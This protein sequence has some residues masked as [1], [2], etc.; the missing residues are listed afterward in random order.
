MMESRKQHGTD[1]HLQLALQRTRA[2]KCKNHAVSYSGQINSRQLVFINLDSD[3]IYTKQNTTAAPTVPVL[4]AQASTTLLTA[5]KTTLPTGGFVDVVN[6]ANSPY[7]AGWALDNVEQLVSV[8]GGMMLVNSD[9][10]SL[11]FASNGSGGFTTPAGD[12]STL[13]QNGNG[14][15][16]RTLADGT[17]IE[18]N[19]SGQETST[20]DTNGNTT[21]FNY[22]GNLLTSITDMNDQTTTLAY[23]NGQLTSIADPANRTATLAYSGSQLT[24]ITDVGGNLWQYGYDASNDLTTLTD[25]NT[26]TTTF[27]YN[28]ADR[29]SS[30]TQ[31]DGTTESLTAEQMNGLAAPGTGTPTNPATSILLAAGDQAQFTDANNNIWTDGLDWLGFGLPVATIDPLGDAALTYIDSNGLAWLSADALAQRTRTFFD[32][33]GD[34]TEIV[35]P[36]DTFSQYSYNSFGEVTQSTNE[37][38]AVTTNTYDS[39]GDLTQTTDALGDITGYAYNAAGLVTAMTNARNYTWN[40]RYDSLNRKIGET[41]PMNYTQSW[42]YDSAGDLTGYTNQNGNLSTYAFNALGEM[43]SETLPD[44]GTTTSTYT[45]AYDG[46]GNQTSETMPISTGVTATTYDSYDAMNRLSTSTD[47]LGNITTYTYDKVGNQIGVTDPLGNV[48]TSTY[49]AANEETAVTTPLSGSGQS[50]VS[51]TTTF[52]YNAVGEQTSATNALGDL[53]QYSYNSR[54]WKTGVI[55]PLGNETLYGYDAVGDQTSVSEMVPQ[56]GLGFGV[57]TSTVY[58]VAYQTTSTYN[59]IG[60]VTT[61]TDNDGGITSYSYDQVGNLLSQSGPVG[62]SCGGSGNMT[63]GYNPNNQ[64][65]TM[66]DGAGDA[67]TSVYDGVGNLTQQTNALGQ[68]TT[69]TFDAQNSLL[70][71]TDALGGITSYAYNLAGWQTTET[72]PVGNITSYAYNT[73]GEMTAETNPLGYQQTLA[74]NQAGELTAQTD[75]NGQVMQYSYNESGWKT[76]ETWLN[77]Q[78]Q[79]IYQAT[80]TYDAAGELTSEQDPNSL[81]NYTY[82][83]G[84]QLTQTA[85]TY[86]GVSSSPL[87][88]LNYGYNDFGD[89]TSLSDSLG[90]S[91]TYAFNGQ[92]QLTGETLALNGTTA[93]QLSMSYD[94]LERLSGITRTGG[95]SSMGNDTIS[96]SYG[97]DAA[98]RLTN[99]TYMDASKY[100]TLASYTYAYNSAGEV[101]SYQDANSSL[102]YGYDTA[103]ELTSASGTLGGSNYSQSWTYDGNGNRTMAGYVTGTG[104]ELLND[105]TYTYTYDKNGNTLTKT[106][107]A[108]GDAWFYTWNY[109]N[110]MTS[111]VEKTSN[112]TVLQNE[113]YTYD[114]E[115]RLI[116]VNVNGVQQRWTV[117]DGSNPYMDF[118]GAGTSVTM[119]YV[120]NPDAYGTL[121]ARVSANGTTN[122]YLTDMLGSIRQ[123]VDTNGSSLDAIVYDPW[124]NIVSESNVANGDRFKF[125]GGV[126]D[127]I[128]QTYLFNVRWLNSQ[129]GRWESR[130]P[131]AL[132]PDSNPYR[133]VVN[134]PLYATDPS[135]MMQNYKLSWKLNKATSFNGDAKAIANGARLGADAEVSAIGS[136]LACFN[137]AFSYGTG[138]HVNLTASFSAT[139]GFIQSGQYEIIIRI[140]S[141]ISGSPVPPNE[142][143]VKWEIYDKSGASSPVSISL[144]PALSNTTFVTLKLNEPAPVP[145]LMIAEGYIYAHAVRAGDAK[146]YTNFSVD[147]LWAKNNGT[148]DVWRKVHPV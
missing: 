132:E 56:K 90:G 63:F 122:W 144:P 92:H 133:Y 40:Y 60:E 99:L 45:F 109:K 103:G 32:N 43:T 65:T 146:A 49:N 9:G 104:N 95:L 114:V 55:D 125:D 123:I 35:N 100:V 89:R 22:T 76:G 25:P 128:Q 38:G 102:T 23:T 34:A 147:S 105:G 70:S 129:D 74:Y 53:W 14:T 130:D 46:V 119:R 52:G 62:C 77:A 97:Y 148:G 12:F 79:P 145:A 3:N 121:Y 2:Y 131:L 143:E 107:T 127:A 72:D 124:G 42:T 108:T 24:S 86:P 115:G 30:V 111:A 140:F 54:G 73:A 142:A 120:T 91:L 29:V 6:Q 5:F 69:S 78:N 137:S 27:A 21:T 1:A 17:Q 87:A 67:T 98:S 50:Q 88:T 59:A 139:K 18:F 10:T 39:K 58:S 31:A 48:T 106:N 11:Y 101:S 83:A 4:N 126:Y 117:F 66:T 138:A 28:F 7:G 82:N 13:V 15:F 8:S 44:S 75:Y 51:A 84:G 135:G 61:V 85:V 68:T 71:T 81:Y 47:A 141:R 26:H 16:T 136:R 41:D 57:I 19:S 36:D 80:L 116:G 94:S 96:S 118:N 20:V 33:Q 113:Q 112:G 134:S 37:L 64:Q 93:A 110:Q